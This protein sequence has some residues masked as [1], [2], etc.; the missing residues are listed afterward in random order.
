MKKALATNH[1]LFD[2]P[3]HH[4]SRQSLWLHRS[5]DAAVD[6]MV[7][8]VVMVVVVVVVVVVVAVRVPFASYFVNPQAAA[9]VCPRPKLFATAPPDAVL[10]ALPRRGRKTPLAPYPAEARLACPY[11]ESTKWHPDPH[12]RHSQYS[13]CAFPRQFPVST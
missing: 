4:L 5:L 7:V 1:G 8:L 2:L 9:R 11:Q 3:P 12:R 6:V 13:L 10:G